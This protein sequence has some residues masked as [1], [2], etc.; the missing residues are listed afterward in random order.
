MDSTFARQC[1]KELLLKTLCEPYLMEAYGKLEFG[2]LS[3]VVATLL[4]RIRLI[5]EIVHLSKYFF[6]DNFEFEEKASEYLKDAQAKQVLSV[7]KQRLSAL[8]QFTKPEIEKTFKD[9]A[10]E[11][12]V[13]LGVV[14]HPCRAALTGRVE[15]PGI[16]DV[17]EVL[18]RE[19]V[20]S[21]LEKVLSA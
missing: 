2:Y 10:K 21:R 11:I 12:G 7:L 15:S 13:K 3:R 9:L 19:R 18:G 8:E 5:P 16:Y 6:V 20:A 14:I 4:D 1:Q 17:I